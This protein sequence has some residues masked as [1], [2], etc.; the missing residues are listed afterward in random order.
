MGVSNSNGFFW[1]R[2]VV[3]G[4]GFAV[5]IATIFITGSKDAWSA[6]IGG[7]QAG[8]G[9]ATSIQ[10]QVNR[11]NANL[12]AY[13][14]R[15]RQIKSMLSRLERFSRKSPRLEAQ[16]ARDKQQVRKLQNLI[17]HQ[18]LTKKRLQSRLAGL[19]QKKVVKAPPERKNVSLKGLLESIATASKS[20]QRK[21]GATPGGLRPRGLPAK[22][23]FGGK[24]AVSVPGFETPPFVTGARWTRPGWFVRG[25]M[26]DLFGD[27]GP[28]EAAHPGHH[29]P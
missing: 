17:L 7:A 19:K 23:Q 1:V 25:A 24:L 8:G 10:R 11:V 15:L 16:V 6:K 4:V 27:E 5:L 13:R 14:S 28:H 9:E 21:T 3:V 29:H 2:S 18:N 22:G 12:R 20:I 26:S